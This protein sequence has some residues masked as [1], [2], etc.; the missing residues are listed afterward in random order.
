[1]IKR[2]NRLL[3]ALG[4]TALMGSAATA[5]ILAQDTTNTDATAQTDSTDAAA[6]SDADQ[7][8]AADT[9]VAEVDGTQILLS[10][11]QTMITSLPPQLSQL[12]PEMVLSLALDQLVTMELILAEARSSGLETD[13]EVLGIVEA[14]DERFM[15]QALVQVWLSRQLQLTDQQL[16]DAFAIYQEANP[17]TELTFEQARPQLEQAVRQQLATELAA[18][19]R[20]GADIIYF[21]A[22]GNPV[23][24]QNGAGAR[25]GESDQNGSAMSTD[26]EPTDAEGEESTESTQ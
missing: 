4:L 8:A 15:D 14:M 1:M 24:Q 20:Q 16:Q 6:D 18:T 25:S 22:T 26:E 7:A 23:Q 12:P 5:P 3:V 19:L 2:N 17:D 11:V 21:D 13:P 10:D 9:V